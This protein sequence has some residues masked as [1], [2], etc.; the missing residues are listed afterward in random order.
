M[1]LDLEMMRQMVDLF[2]YTNWSNLNLFESTWLKYFGP[3]L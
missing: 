1:P 3:V 2:A